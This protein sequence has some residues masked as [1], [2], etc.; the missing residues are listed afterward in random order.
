MTNFI[1]GICK[2]CENCSRSLLECY[3][4]VFGNGE[5]Q[6]KVSGIMC[7]TYSS[8]DLMIIPDIADV[9]V[10]QSCFL[11]GRPK[12]RSWLGEVVS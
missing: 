4:V 9:S 6:K 11:S 1:V 10:K 8:L 12:L 7:G 5:V 3:E 2:L